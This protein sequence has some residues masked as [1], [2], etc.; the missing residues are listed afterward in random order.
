M[1]W[2]IDIIL[3]IN[4]VLLLGLVLG[5]ANFLVTKLLDWSYPGWRVSKV[6]ELLIEAEKTKDV[7]GSRKQRCPEIAKMKKDQRIKRKLKNAGQLD[8]WQK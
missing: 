8:L 7:T 3:I 6:G 4:F 1:D 2:K 5:A